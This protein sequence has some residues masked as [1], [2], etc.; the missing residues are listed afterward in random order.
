MIIR[1]RWA[2]LG[3]FSIITIMLAY[4]ATR[5]EINNDHA[6]W[7]PRNDEVAKL[8][9]QVD[10]E[11]SSNVMVFTIIDFSDKGVF[12]PDSLALLERI[13]VELEGMKE[14]FNVTSIT[15]IIDIRKTDDGI[16]VGDLMSGIPRTPEALEELKDYVLSKELYVNSI[17]SADCNFSTIMTNIESSYDEVAIAQKIFY[18]VGEIAGERPHYFGGDPAVHYY[19]NE[20]MNRDMRILVPVMLVVMLFVLAFGLRRVTGVMFPLTLVGLAIVWT[21]GLM[22]LFVLP[23][24]VLSPAVAVLLIAIGSDYAVHVYNHYLK[25]G[26]VLRSTS[27]IAVPV[28]MSALTTIAGLLAFA[29]TKIEVLQNFG[30]ELAFGLGSACVMSIILLAIGLYIFRVKASPSGTECV[31]DDHIF[32]RIMVAT[33]SVVHDHARVILAVALVGLVIMGYGIS[34]IR[35]NVDFIGQLPKNSPPRQGCNILMDHFNGMYP[36]NLYV[37]GDLEHPAVMNSMNYLE[38]YLRCEETVDGHTSVNSLIA[39]ENWLLNGVYAVP[40]TRQ[41]IANLWFMLEG[42]DILKTFVSTERDKGLVNSL[43]KESST[44]KMRHLANRLEAFMVHNVS[45]EVVTID[46]GKLTHQ[47]RLD[48]EAAALE[49]ASSQL[50]WLSGFYDRSNA[51]DGPVFM[52]RLSQRIRTLS[53]HLNYEPV[54]LEAERYLKE[55]TLEVLPGT[56]IE[57]IMTYVLRNTGRTDI[58]LDQ[59][60]IEQMIVQASAMDSQD[61]RVTSQGLMK[62]IDSSLRLQKVDA[63]RGSFDDLLSPVLAGDK[64]FSKRAG[65]VLWEYLSKKPTFF[66]QQ[67]SSV[68]GI[69]SAVEETTSVHINQAGMPETIRVIHK[70]LISSQLQSLVLASII[71]LVL[72][73]LTQRSFRRGAISLLSVLVPLEF[74]LG[75]M[76]LSNIPLDLGTV[77]CGAL[78]IGLGIDGSIHFLHYYHQ[79]QKRGIEGK[80]ALELTMGHVGRAVITANATTFCGFV[81]LLFSQTTAVRNFSMVNSMAILLVTISVLTLLPALITVIHLSREKDLAEADMGHVAKRVLEMKPEYIEPVIIKKTNAGDSCTSATRRTQESACKELIG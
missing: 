46:P 71:V 5:L 68:E 66:L 30:V 57:E 11:F 37:Q 15:N 77:L 72:V 73:S 80:R 27:E 60:L 52:D 65:G 40:E 47:G 14:L 2:L 20:Y 61:A 10:E 24:N 6:S 48:L 3:L 55:E 42:Q 62:R 32:S 39:E 21:F 74:I 28:V 54:W 58:L 79:V 78:I 50:S 41:G 13:T 75:F 7:L 31:D 1:Y 59:P 17:V 23:I 36:F 64:D 8:L 19:M 16:E 22:S 81:V 44:G 53:T 69:G 45:E 33:A 63:L 25:R 43:V 70:L 4:G 38:N 51:V 9:L 26:D 67:V 49:R 29:T 56:L 34:K 12:H 35:T 18:K 76:G